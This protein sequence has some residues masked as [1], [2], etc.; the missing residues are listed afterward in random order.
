M[1]GGILPHE[2]GGVPS[3]QPKQGCSPGH[4]PLSRSLHGTPENLSGA[5]NYTRVSQHTEL[6]ARGDHEWATLFP[7][8]ALTNA[9]NPTT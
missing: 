7:A 3:V 4:E 6:R 5:E 1:Q 2:E 9:Q 8:A